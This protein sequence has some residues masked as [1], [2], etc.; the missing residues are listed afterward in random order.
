MNWPDLPNCR[1]S[2]RL[3]SE[4]HADR[5]MPTPSPAAATETGA[6]APDRVGQNPPPRIRAA[7][8][9]APAPGW[10]PLPHP[11]PPPLPE[12]S[13]LGATGAGAPERQRAGR[14]QPVAHG[15]VA[16]PAP[17]PVRRLQPDPGGCCGRR[18]KSR[19]T[20]W[21]GRC[22]GRS[23][24]AQ[25]TGRRNHS[26]RDNP[27]GTS[28]VSPAPNRQAACPSATTVLQKSAR[29]FIHVS[30]TETCSPTAT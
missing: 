6:S 27:R 19:S 14:T 1:I 8:V 4:R 23:P 5:A 17:P 3:A 2:T 12:R 13:P 30:S 18:R 24:L 20:T 16:Q 29:S 25:F 26:G 9:G 7:P 11:G 22:R 15:Q 10:G 21:A 28:S